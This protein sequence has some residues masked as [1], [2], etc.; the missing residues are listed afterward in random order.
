MLN[1]NDCTQTFVLPCNLYTYATI[2]VTN[3]GFFNI[4]TSKSDRMYQCSTDSLLNFDCDAQIKNIFKAIAF[5][6]GNIS[7]AQILISYTVDDNTFHNPTVAVCTALSIIDSQKVPQSSQLKP[8]I[9]EKYDN[10][11]SLFAQLH[12]RQN[13]IISGTKTDDNIALPFDLSNHKILLCKIKSE[14]YEQKSDTELTNKIFENISHTETPNSELY[15]I[16]EQLYF[17][18]GKKLKKDIKRLYKLFT[19]TKETGLCALNTIDFRNGT[20]T[21]IVKNNNTDNFINIFS[22]VYNQIEGDIPK[23]YIC[24]SCDSAIEVFE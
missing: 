2:R 11:S 6:K 9:C 4:I 21:C 13:T 17:Q 20:F 8:F 3:N 14:N 10:T 23:L 22:E 12:A 19:L 5:L 18:D 1:P 15:N 24:D 16:L 7:G